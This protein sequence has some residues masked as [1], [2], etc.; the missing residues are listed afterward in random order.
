MTHNENSITYREE[1][2]Q[3]LSKAPVLNVFNSQ[4]S[5]GELFRGNYFSDFN[6]SLGT[7]GDGCEGI[8]ELYEKFHD[9]KLILKA[10]TGSGKSTALLYLY[11]HG[12]EGKDNN[13]YFAPVKVLT[14][15][16]SSLLKYAREIFDIFEKKEKVEGTFLLDG[17]EES[18]AA[19]IDG[20][21]EILEKIAS[22]PNAVWIACRPDFYE[23]VVKDYISYFDAVAE[24]DS[25][26]PEGFKTF[27]GNFKSH[28]GYAA[29]AE[30]VQNLAEGFARDRNSIIYRPLYATMMLFIEKEKPGALGERADFDEY[31]L[32]DNF[33]NYWFE[34]NIASNQ[35]TAPETCTDFK[36]K[37]EYINQLIDIALN[38]KTGTKSSEADD[39]I[40]AF[41]VI[42]GT[43]IIQDFHHREFLN[44]FLVKGLLSA[45]LSDDFEK[46]V[47]WYSQ[48]FFDADVMR[49][50]R[51][52]LRSLEDEQAKKICN[53]L[54]CKY[55]ESFEK[56]G[57]VKGFLKKNKITSVNKAILKLRAALTLCI[58]CFPDECVS[59]KVVNHSGNALEI[60][61]EHSSD[62]SAG[63]APISP[64]GES[65]GAFHRNE[66]CEL[67]LNDKN[68][69]RNRMI[70]F[71]VLIWYYS[72]TKF[73]DCKSYRDY[74]II[75]GCN[76]TYALYNRE[77]QKAVNDLKNHLVGLYKQHLL[78]YIINQNPQ[79]D[80]ESTAEAYLDQNETLLLQRQ[81][82]LELVNES[83]MSFWNQNK[84][85][86]MKDCEIKKTDPGCQTILDENT[87][88]ENV[89]QCNCIIITANRI[90]GITVTRQLQALNG[91]QKLP[92]YNTD[93]AHYQF[94]TVETI[95]ILHIWPRNTSSFSL[96]GSFNA[97]LEA[98][99]FFKGENQMP[100]YVFAVGVA[101][102][103]NLTKLN[104][105]DVLISDSLV[106]YDAFN[107]RTDGVLKL[108]RREVI[109]VS[110]EIHQVLEMKIADD[111]T[112]PS[113]YGIGQFKWEK[114][115]LLSGGTVLSDAEEKILLADASLRVG[116]EVIGGEMEGSGIYFACKSVDPPIPFVI[117]K[118][119]CD[120]GANKNGWQ[121]AVKESGNK[122]QSSDIKDCV[123]TL[124]CTNAFAV[125]KY[126]IKELC[127]DYKNESA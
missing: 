75:S 19:D 60:L 32:L 41:L 102:G 29:A 11:I 106:F 67:K 120:W 105:G 40:K 116:A 33:V 123:Q 38:L 76:V 108:D 30:R 46:I 15:P 82:S 49:L 77:Q 10:P 51:M 5:L 96:H 57:K 94:A 114:G 59:T 21:K 14:G 111:M 118:G 50:F 36:T 34:Q 71:Q 126:M 37:E 89:K 69:L 61:A 79:F 8:K 56:D 64:I 121:F 42:P 6:F 48:T 17:F 24:V 23:S 39:L 83:L 86:L 16:S 99:K 55:A 2:V 91:N 100:K 88:K 107:K 93:E 115:P 47:V 66:I 109:N 44:Y 95:P 80:R 54:V 81:E 22:S 65:W 113:H 78:S 18:F 110:D 45:A 53:H 63:I 26:S 7:S 4:L 58:L 62:L 125:V 92:R 72:S 117:V 70:H 35:S 101:F 12:I 28:K 1:N 31:Y 103:G 87:F 112:G 3:S 20:A 84:T 98:L 43:K 73:V 13:T 124:A 127:T 85:N 119:I 97:L 122:Y 27:I 25:W 90:E 68:N 52:S 74:R 104:L 9:K